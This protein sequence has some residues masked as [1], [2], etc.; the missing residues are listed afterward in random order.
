MV[1][2]EPEAASCK[3]CGEAV[4][5]APESG[6]DERE[7]CASCFRLM[8]RM[9]RMFLPEGA[10]VRGARA[11]PAPVLTGPSESL[12]PQRSAAAGEA[13]R[14]DA[15]RTVP[16]S[17]PDGVAGVP[18]GGTSGRSGAGKRTAI[19]LLLAA[20]IAA[21]AW[22]AYV[23]LAADGAG[24]VGPESG[25]SS[26]E[27]PTKRDS[28]RNSPSAD[29]RVPG[30]ATGPGPL[31]ASPGSA[32]L[33]ATD[34]PALEAAV[35]KDVTI[36]GRIARIGMDEEARSL[37]LGFSA[38]ADSFEAWIPSRRFDP[39]RIVLGADLAGALQGQIVRIHGRPFR[40]DGRVRVTLDSPSQLDVPQK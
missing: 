36:Q 26:K 12:P 24:T 18:G 13:A 31:Q 27:N 37:V 2:L 7:Y 25:G 39:F 1:G 4:G 30:A 17:S 35:G 21:A 9:E 3:A 32:P 5:T 6:P 8:K 11:T 28:S 16:G 40:K 20:G 22:L 38:E 29:G 23:L 19:L 10:I 33:S 15:A 14:A 34:R